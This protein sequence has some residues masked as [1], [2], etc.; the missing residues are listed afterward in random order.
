MAWKFNKVT[1]TDAQTV[2]QLK[3]SV[4]ELEDAPAGGGFV[5]FNAG[6]ASKGQVHT[7]RGY[8]DAIT[9]PNAPSAEVK[10]ADMVELT[11]YAEFIG[12]T[13]T[14]VFNMI[15]NGDSFVAQYVYQFADEQLFTVIWQPEEN[16]IY[17]TQF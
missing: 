5:A 1:G 11:M 15:K 3:R 9:L 16:K 2:E 6:D 10:A 12:S 13:D 17:Y 8:A 14:Y 7:G 4:S